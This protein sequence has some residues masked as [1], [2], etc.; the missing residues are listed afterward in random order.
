MKLYNNCNSVALESRMGD[1]DFPMNN[2]LCIKNDINPA[3]GL[4]MVNSLIDV[5]GHSYGTD[6]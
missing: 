6:N 4:P 1:F 2:N 3:S 5:G